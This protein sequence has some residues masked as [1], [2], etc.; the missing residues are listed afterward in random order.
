MKH[1]PN[2]TNK[3]R[4]QQKHLNALGYLKAVDKLFNLNQHQLQLN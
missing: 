3:L 2:V 4:N 1:Q